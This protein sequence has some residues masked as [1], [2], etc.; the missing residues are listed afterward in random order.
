M[1]K[2]VLLQSRSTYWTNRESQEE[3]I[4]D[5]V[6]LAQEIERVCNE[7]AKDGYEVIQLTPVSSGSMS[8][9][10]GYFQT[11]SMIVLAKKIEK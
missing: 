7:L 10:N 11:A 5:S 1:Y 9:G 6:D 3:L 8:N 4:V 2:T